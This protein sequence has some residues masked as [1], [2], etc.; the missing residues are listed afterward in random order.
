[1]LLL[2]KSMFGGLDYW[3]INMGIIGFNWCLEFLRIDCTGGKKFLYPLS[4]RSWDLQNNLT[5]DRL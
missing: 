4:F 3:N 5:K 1:M 2:G